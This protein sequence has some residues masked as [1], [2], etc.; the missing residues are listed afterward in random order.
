M[1]FLTAERE[2]VNCVGVNDGK[3]QGVNM[4]QKA[5]RMS[6]ILHQLMASVMETIPNVL[7]APL[8]VACVVLRPISRGRQSNGC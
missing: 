1:G 7:G 2:L 5:A 3:E 8:A 6:L 4:R